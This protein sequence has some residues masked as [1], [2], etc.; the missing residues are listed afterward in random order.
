MAFVAEQT[1]TAVWN[2]LCDLEFH[3]RYFTALA[4]QFR[5]RH[6]LVR[7]GILGSVPVEGVLLYFGTVEP[8]LFWAAGVVFVQLAFLTIWDAIADYAED[9]ALLRLTAYACEDL[10]REIEELFRRIERGD[11]D[12]SEAEAV[13]RS[14]EARWAV[15]TQR[16]QVGTNERINDSASRDANLDVQN[17]YAI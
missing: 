16:V 12:T 4:D 7:G 8:L 1:R 17:R 3:V 10:Q 6:R 14:I 9:G 15:A 5:F 11:L 13:N 2:N